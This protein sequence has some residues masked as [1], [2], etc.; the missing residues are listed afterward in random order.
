MISDTT[1]EAVLD[2]WKRDKITLEEVKKLLNIEGEGVK[3]KQP[4]DLLQ[5]PPVVIPW[6][7]PSVWYEQPFTITCTSDNQ[8][9]INYTSRKIL[10]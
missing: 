3:W 2:L 10:A 5:Q 6:I 4:Q 8:M 7:Q 9:T 1:L